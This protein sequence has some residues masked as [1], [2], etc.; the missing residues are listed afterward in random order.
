MQ[1]QHSMPPASIDHPEPRLV[2]LV[3]DIVEAA[4]LQNPERNEAERSHSKVRHVTNLLVEPMLHPV[5]QTYGLHC[6]L[7]SLTRQ[8]DNNRIRREPVVLVENQIGRASCR[9]RV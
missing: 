4:L 5:D 8:P 3:I 2:N 7:R 6:V 1:L 9:E